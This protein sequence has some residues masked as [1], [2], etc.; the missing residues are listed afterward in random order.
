MR[1]CLFQK[2]WVSPSDRTPSPGVGVGQ[3]WG[4]VEGKSYIPVVVF[5][6]LFEYRSGG[7]RGV[8]RGRRAGIT[9]AC[10]PGHPADGLLHSP[11]PLPHTSASHCNAFGWGTRWGVSRSGSSAKRPQ[12]RTVTTCVHS[13]RMCVCEQ[14]G[15]PVS[16]DVH[17]DRSGH[18]SS[19]AC[20]FSQ[21]RTPRLIKT[22][23]LEV[24]DVTNSAYDDCAS[25]SCT[26]IAERTSPTFCFQWPDEFVLV[27]SAVP[28]CFVHSD[29]VLSWFGSLIPF[30]KC[31]S[32][33]GWGEGGGRA[34]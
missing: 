16:K 24:L 12:C 8:S 6:R 28:P 20:T 22:Y 27:I 32:V 11:G 18:V 3:Q 14:V 33:R 31:M 15:T 4:G 23:Q 1:A 21:P 7:V 26:P 30:T 2:N 9:R 5:R 19:A 10:A 34:C 13:G 25:S 17:C 29:G